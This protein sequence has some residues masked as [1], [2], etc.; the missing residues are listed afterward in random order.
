MQRAN[1]NI[2]SYGSISLGNEVAAFIVKSQQ[3]DACVAISH[4]GA[5]ESGWSDIEQ[6]GHFAAARFSREFTTDR[7][8]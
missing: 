7:R 6:R 8:D 3:D 1:D 4:D 5:N 2:V